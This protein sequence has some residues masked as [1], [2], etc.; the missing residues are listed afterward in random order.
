MKGCIIGTF[1]TSAPFEPVKPQRREGE[2]VINWN[3]RKE[4]YRLQCKVHALRHTLQQIILNGPPCQHDA[5]CPLKGGVG[6]DQGCA[7]CSV[8]LA[9][10]GLKHEDNTGK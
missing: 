3:I 10:E 5:D 1:S 4:N 7:R 2:D 6:F 9:V 8:V